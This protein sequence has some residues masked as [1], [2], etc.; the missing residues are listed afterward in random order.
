MLGDFAFAV[1]D[2]ANATLFCAR[3]HFGVKPFYYS[4]SS[5]RFAFASEIKALLALPGM[6]RELNEA[7]IADFLVALVSDSSSTFYSRVLRLPAGHH[8]TV[9]PLGRRLQSYWRPGP[10][11]SRV[12]GDAAEQFRELFFRAV[13]CR[14]RGIEL[15]LAPC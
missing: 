14:L 8:M 1:W 3:D 2:G 10:S 15:S 12:V 11:R 4:A 7:P 5:D 9:T 13:Q 6:D